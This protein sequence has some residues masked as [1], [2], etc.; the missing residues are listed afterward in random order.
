MQLDAVI[1][2]DRAAGD[3]AEDLLAE[4]TFICISVC[5]AGPPVPHA[6]DHRS[7]R[8]ATTIDAVHATLVDSRAAR[9]GATVPGERLPRCAFSSDRANA[10][11]CMLDHKAKGGRVLPHRF[12]RDDTA[13]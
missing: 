2:S 10:R 9:L 1:S 6:A 7:T 5:G 13:R 4:Q 11:R 12:A 3:S 8:L